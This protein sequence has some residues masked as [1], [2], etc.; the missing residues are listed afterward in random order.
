MGEKTCEDGGENVSAIETNLSIDKSKNAFNV[1][2]P[3]QKEGISGNQNPGSN[4]ACMT[5]EKADEYLKG[6]L[7]EDVIKLQEKWVY[8]LRCRV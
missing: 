8:L 2:F 4:I 1:P 3:P 7:K 6:K 5:P